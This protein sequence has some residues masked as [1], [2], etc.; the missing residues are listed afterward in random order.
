MTPYDGLFRNGDCG[1]DKNFICQM[2]GGQ[3]LSSTTTTVS[4]PAATTT[5]TTTTAPSSSGPQCN[6]GEVQRRTR[7]VGG[8]DT[9]ENEYPWKVKILNIVKHCLHV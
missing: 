7:I 1:E 8:I 2:E 9:E 6:C 4:N 3:N 5:T